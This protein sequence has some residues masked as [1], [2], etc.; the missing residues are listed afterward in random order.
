MNCTGIICEYNPFHKGHLYHMQE[1]RR[2]S[3]NDH[4]IAVM[5]GNFVQRGEPAILD[6]WRRTEM[7]LRGGASLVIEIPTCLSTASS[8]FYAGAGVRLLQ[9]TGIC[10]TISYGVESLNLSLLETVSNIVF[11]EPIEYTTLLKS[12]MDKGLGY[13]AARAQALVD[14]THCSP[15]LI[16]SPNLILAVE[17]QKA[18]LRFHAGLCSVPVQRQGQYHDPSINT[19]L[20]SASAIRKA[21][22]EQQSIETSMPSWAVDILS[23]SPIAEPLDAWSRELYY[24]LCYHTAE[25]LREIP[26][27]TEGLEN[28]ILKYTDRPRT[29]SELVTLLS[30]KRYPRSRI[31]RIL[32]RIL[33]DIRHISTPEYIRVLGFRKDHKEVLTALTK[34]AQVPV[35]TN[36]ARQLPHLSESIQHQL[37]REILYTDLYAA[38][39]PGASLRKGAELT[40]PIIRI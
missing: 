26:D 19:P 21:L 2:L 33:L 30:S 12:Y 35:I 3:G 16:K 40:Q 4:I 24:R 15:E 22:R 31:R 39:T 25:S 34:N 6:K 27:V 11:H 1:A 20:P 38:H 18:N 23:E 14:L 9:L 5:S 13:A 7:A 8:E 36:L 37:Q 29:I 28:R 10:N 17:Y 32:L